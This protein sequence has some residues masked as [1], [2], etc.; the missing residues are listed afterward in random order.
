MLFII[1]FFIKSDYPRHIDIVENVTVLVWMLSIL[2]SGV[3]LFDWAHESD[4][5]S[6]N[7]PVKITVFNSL[8][9]LVLFHVESFEVV[10][11]EFY[12]VLEPLEHLEE[13]AVVEAVTFGGVSV[14]FEELVVRLELLVG[15][16]GR[17]LQNDDHEGAHQEG[18]VHHLGAW[19][20]RGA[21]VEHSVVRVVLVTEESCELT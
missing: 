11:T 13:R 17:H 8:V 21:V 19:L 7:D 18:S 4:E 12:C 14:V 20:R 2:V 1:F 16:V 6:W 15:V 10:P 5:L 3:S 9:V